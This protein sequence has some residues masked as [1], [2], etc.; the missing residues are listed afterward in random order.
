MIRLTDDRTQRVGQHRRK[1]DDARLS[2]GYGAQQI[3][4][5]LKALAKTQTV[6][7]NAI[8]TAQQRSGGHNI[9]NDLIHACGSPLCAYMQEA[10]SFRKRPPA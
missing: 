7:E 6:S 8:Q 2:Q 3:E 10:A 4:A 5:L 9:H 1:A